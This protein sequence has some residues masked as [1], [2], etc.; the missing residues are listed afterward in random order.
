MISVLAPDNASHEVPTAA[1]LA[2]LRAELLRL[3]ALEESR[4][5]A[6][7]AKVPYWAPCPASVSGHRAAAQALRDDAQRLQAT[8]A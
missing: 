3:A 7:A 6:E 8:A 4:A 2:A 5:T 1:I